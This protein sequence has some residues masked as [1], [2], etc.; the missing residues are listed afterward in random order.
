MQ[1]TIHEP[2]LLLNL[3]SISWL[4]DRQSEQ[5]H[6]TTCAPFKRRATDSWLSLVFSS[7]LH[8]VLTDWCII[9]KTVTRATVKRSQFV[10]QQE[11]TV[12]VG[13]SAWNVTH[14]PASSVTRTRFCLSYPSGDGNREACL[15]SPFSPCFTGWYFAWCVDDGVMTWEGK[16][17]LPDSRLSFVKFIIS[18]SLE[19][20]KTGSSWRWRLLALKSKNKH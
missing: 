20:W 1:L 4:V 9:W 14:D 2:R 11:K 7:S 3:A 12:W 8:A 6:Q 17:Q 15:E 18:S 10:W 16:V 19:V 13:K 5:I